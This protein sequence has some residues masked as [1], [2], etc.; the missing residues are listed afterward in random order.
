MKRLCIVI[1]KGLI[2]LVCIDVKRRPGWMTIELSSQRRGL[3]CLSSNVA[4]VM[5]D[6]KEQC[7]YKTSRS[8]PDLSYEKQTNCRLV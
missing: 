2:R 6:A 3:L 4:A 8:P 1:N 7:P 5:S